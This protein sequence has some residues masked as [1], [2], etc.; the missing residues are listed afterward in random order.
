MEVMRIMLFF[1]LWILS[2]AAWAEGISYT[3]KDLEI[4]EE[5]GSY[6]DFF[7]HAKDVRPALRGKSWERM[8]RHMAVAW[9]NFKLK[10]K[11]FDRD[12]FRTIEGIA[13]WPTLRQDEFF[14]LKRGEYALKT[15]EHCF[16]T[17]EAKEYST[18]RKWME[19]FWVRSNRLVMVGHNLAK[20]LVE[21]KQSGAWVFLSEV[22]SKEESKDYCKDSFIQDE[23]LKKISSDNGDN[24]ENA[25]HPACWKA[26]VPGLRQ[27]LL[28][29]NG[30]GN[31][32]LFEIFSEKGLLKQEEEDFYYVLF[33]L[34]GPEVGKTF[35]LAWN[36][37][38]SLG[39]DFSRR[40]KVLQRLVKMDPLPD[41]VVGTNHLAKRKTLL[42][43]FSLHFPE[44][45]NHYSKVCLNYLEGRGSWPQGNPTVRC[46]DFFRYTDSLVSDRLYLRYSALKKEGKVVD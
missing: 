17:A 24:P 45:F 44:Y 18:C 40:E 12:S 9:V 15:F 5:Q 16:V 22:L 43:F 34:N 25:F 21:Q 4:L 38:K 41:G 19:H 14:Q 39:Q 31:D 37:M 1:S 26:M 10:R 32:R 7:R 30:Q 29:G 35:N 46:R 42:E 33:I 23:F 11:M 20:L 36:R 2:G 3:L 27:H 6:P 28:N 8:V 13:L